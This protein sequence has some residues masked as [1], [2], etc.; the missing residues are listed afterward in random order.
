[1]KTISIDVK[2]GNDQVIESNEDIAAYF[3]E[4]KTKT[5][6][7]RIAADPQLMAQ[8]KAAIDTSAKE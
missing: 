8:L 1:M 4:C 2:T 3:A 5:V 7:D 6:I